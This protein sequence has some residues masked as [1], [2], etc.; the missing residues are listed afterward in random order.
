[1]R[2]VRRPCFLMKAIFVVTVAMVFTAQAATAADAKLPVLG[3]TGTLPALL[4]LVRD[5]NPSLRSQSDRVAAA[6]YEVEA[7]D[8]F[9][10][11]TISAAAGFAEGAMRTPGSLLPSITPDKSWVTEAALERPLRH[12]GVKLRASVGRWDSIGGGEIDN[13]SG[14]IAG[15]VIEKPLWRDRD[16]AMQRLEREAAQHGVDVAQ[17]RRLIVWQD[18]CHNMGVAYVDWLAACAEMKESQA[19]Y[20][21]VAQLLQETEKRVELDTTPAYQLAPARMEVAFS[22]D[23]LYQ[24]QAALDAAR[25][26]IMEVAGGSLPPDYLPEPAESE[27]RDWADACARVAGDL[28]LGLDITVRHEWRAA[29]AETMKHGALVRRSREEMKSDLSLFGGAGWRLNNQPSTRGDSDFG[30]EAGIV[31]RRPWGFAAEKATTAAREA[32][33]NAA[34]AELAAVITEIEAEFSRA[35]TALEAACR[36]LEWVDRAVE[37]AR[38][39]LEA[40]AERFRLGE[41]RSRLVLDAQKDLTTANRS[42]NAAAAQTIR[43]YINQARAAGIDF[44]PF[45]ATP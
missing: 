26:K 18:T 7:V 38:N 28:P 23:A 5:G 3:V 17:A 35:T 31:W 43:A 11:T 41:G 8:G 44:L 13:N 19:A 25:I 2:F 15:A 30:W 24:A 29:S 40:E 27:L 10:D 6:A 1:M 12:G 16:F 34:Q 39:N 33:A 36:R 9:F 20:G 21:R 42:A 14:T 45:K 37:A 4:E 22:Q 32:E